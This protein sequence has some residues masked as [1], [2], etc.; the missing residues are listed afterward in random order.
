MDN[1]LEKRLEKDFPFIKKGMSLKE[2]K[3]AGSINDL[4]SAFGCECAD[5]WFDLIYDLCS[6][7]MQAYNDEN[8]EI[9]LEVLQIKEKFGTLR[10]YY[11]FKGKPGTIQGFDFI[12]NQGVGGFRFTPEGTEFEKKIS[13]IVRKYEEKSGS[14]CDNCGGTGKLRTDLSWIRTLCDECYLKEKY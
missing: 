7:I 10:F 1:L 5:G 6:E 3:E 2:Q 8:R 13:D 11:G 4:Y 9:D 12:G 14:V